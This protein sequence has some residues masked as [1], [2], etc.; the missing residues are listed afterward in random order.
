MG[1][2]ADASNDTNYT[3]LHCAAKIG[4]TKIMTLLL[5]RGARVDVAST[6][7]TALLRA[8]CIG[9]RDA[10]KV[11]LDHGAN[12]NVVCPRGMLRPLMSAII[13]KSWE[14]M[15]LLLQ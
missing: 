7:G 4:N 14:S 1:A 11:L 2:N 8:A 12:P 10:I 3:P 15:E 13:A 5:K 6:N 9:H